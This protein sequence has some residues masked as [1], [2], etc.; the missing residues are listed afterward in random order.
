MFRVRIATAFWV[1]S[2]D[3]SKTKRIP[4]GITL[5]LGRSVRHTKV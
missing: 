5:G 2:T 4:K 3:E 1:M